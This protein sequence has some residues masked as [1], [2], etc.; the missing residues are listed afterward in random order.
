MARTPRG[1][2]SNGVYHVISRGVERRCIYSSDKDRRVFLKQLRID[3]AAAGISVFAYCLMGNHFHMLLASAATPLGVAMHRLLQRYAIYFNRS[4]SRVGH[5]FQDRYTAKPCRNLGHILQLFR[6]I[7]FN[8]VRAKLVSSPEAWPWSSHAEFVG[9][10]GR[11]LNLKKLAEII[12]MSVE[13][14][15]GSYAESLRTPP[16]AENT[17]RGVIIEA[18]AE[19]GVDPDE[20][21]TGMR[22]RDYSRAKRRAIELA[23]RR[24]VRLSELAE[25]FGCT[26]SSLYHLRDS[27]P[28]RR[29]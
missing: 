10:R 24:G 9:G 21:L 11:Q 28:P 27:A 5:L 19:T 17:A 15:R 23:S 14:I 8:P 16:P 18:A 3:F 29:Y 20:L 4:Y 1:N 26:E 2:T 7:H 12:G 22:G 25:L 13:D 6:Y